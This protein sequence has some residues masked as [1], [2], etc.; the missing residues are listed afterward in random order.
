MSSA[1]PNTKFFGRVCAWMGHFD[2]L[3]EKEAIE[4][5]AS[6]LTSCADSLGQNVALEYPWNN[7][8]HREFVGIHGEIGFTLAGG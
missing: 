7:K 5:N 8:D 3:L 1:K 4:Y 2:A 6:V